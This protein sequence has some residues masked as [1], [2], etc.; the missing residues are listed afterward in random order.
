[1]RIQTPFYLV[2][3][4]LAFLRLPGIRQQGQTSAV[5]SLANKDRA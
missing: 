1:M 4:L 3:Q 5:H 2:K